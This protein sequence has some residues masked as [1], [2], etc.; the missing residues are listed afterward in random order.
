VGE[1]I[2]TVVFC[3]IVQDLSDSPYL[4]QRVIIVEIYTHEYA[5]R[6]ATQPTLELLAHTAITSTLD[7]CKKAACDACR[8]FPPISKLDTAQQELT[9]F[10]TRLLGG[11]AASTL[12]A[13]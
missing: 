12:P 2:P 6:L 7:M 9:C 11:A 8:E 5:Q 4:G 1:S 13:S 3:K 10:Q